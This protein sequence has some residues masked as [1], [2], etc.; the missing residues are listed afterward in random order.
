MAGTAFTVT[1]TATTDGTTPDSAFAGTE[2]LTLSGPGLS[3]D[4]TAPSY[5]A[6]PP[7]VTF[8]GGVGTVSITLFKA[9]NPRLTAVGSLS[10]TSASWT[11]NA[12]PATALCI[13]AATTCTGSSRAGAQRATFTSAVG[14]VDEYLNPAQSTVSVAVAVALT[15]GDGTGPTT[16]GSLTIPAGQT[17]TSGTFTATA[18]NGNGKTGTFTATSSPSLTSATVRL[19]T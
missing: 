9:E 19:T 7:S 12:K 8:A 18:A 11:V 3:P 1:I 13:I 16:T 6:V 10:G 5:A 15:S 14:L 2:T 4:N 17:K